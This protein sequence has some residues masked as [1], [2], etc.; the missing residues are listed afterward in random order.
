[1]RASVAFEDGVCHS[2]RGRNLGRLASPERGLIRMVEEH[3][4]NFGNFRKLENRIGFPIDAGH[5]V[6]VKFQLPL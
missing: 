4:I 1:M 3:N 6:F 2:R 5:T